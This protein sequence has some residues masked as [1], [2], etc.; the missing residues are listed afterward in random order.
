MDSLRFLRMRPTA[1]DGVVWSVSVCMSACLL[2]ATVSRVK[3]DELIEMSFGMWTRGLG[4]SIERAKG[5]V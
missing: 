3:T 2:V 1:A 5:H 4:S